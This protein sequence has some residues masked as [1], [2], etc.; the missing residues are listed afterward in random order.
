LAAGSKKINLQ[1]LTVGTKLRLKG[2][3]VAE[4]VSNPRDGVWVIARLL[5]CPGSPS[6]VGT[7]EMI[8]T[9]DVLEVVEAS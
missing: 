3:I 6:Q 7:E 2:D 8:F 4:V 9:E 5:S 1:S